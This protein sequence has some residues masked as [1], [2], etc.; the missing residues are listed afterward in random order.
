MRLDPA[1][2]QKLID[3][4][5]LLM[6]GGHP[7]QTYQ[8]FIEKNPQLL[9]RE[10]IQ[11]HGLHF[12][13]AIR[14]LS[15]AS[16]YT[17]DFFYLAKSSADWHCVLVEIEKPHSQYFKEGSNDFHPQFISAL[18]QINRWRAWFENRSNFEG[19]V[20]GTIRPLRVPEGMTR[21]P[22]Y[23]KYVLVH[24][25]RSEFD[26][27]EQRAAM[28]RAQERDDFRIMS[29]DSLLED[30]LSK[31]D[32]YVAIRKNEK[33]EITTSHFV[34]DTVFVWMDPSYLRV[35]QA[36]RDDIEASQDKWFHASMKGGKAMEGIL[37]KLL[38]ADV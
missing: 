35:S 30:L 28:I 3:E 5:S 8:S 16:D 33:Y 26:R 17:T 22:C 2:A 11:N 12:S 20:N 24:G 27:N 25:R 38:V 19:F 10:F 21:N 7:E 31:S 37:P 32:L 14:K 13:T 6:D 9:P 15:L 4:F 23:I 36:L 1:A 18:A 34:N 29:Y